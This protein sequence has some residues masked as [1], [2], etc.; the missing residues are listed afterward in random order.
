MP[1]SP[2][3]FKNPST[4]FDPTPYGFSHLSIAS[5]GTHLI[6]T[7]GQTPIDATG[8]IPEPFDAQVRATFTSLKACLAEAGAGLENIVNLTVYVVN[9]EANSNVMERMREMLTLSDGST[10]HPPAAVIP[11][12]V[13]AVEIVAVAVA[14]V[15]A[16]SA[17]NR[18]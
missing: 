4:L 18:L 3:T 13:L 11:V 9:Y 1:L 15:A 10:L 5:P 2:L 17:G 14:A 7:A 6:H 8:N 12:P 16:A